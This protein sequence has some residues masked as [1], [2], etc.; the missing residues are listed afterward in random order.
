M[1]AVVTW[2]SLRILDLNGAVLYTATGSVNFHNLLTLGRKLGLSSRSSADYNGVTNPGGFK[3]LD[4]TGTPGS[5]GFGS[6]DTTFAQGAGTGAD[7]SCGI[8][9]ADATGRQIA[10]GTTTE[11]SGT[12]YTWN[13]GNASKHMFKIGPDGQPAA[14][15]NTNI[16]TGD[17]GDTQVCGIDSHGRVYFTG[18][19]MSVN[20]VATSALYRLYRL[21]ASGGLDQELDGFDG[22][23]NG[24]R[25]LDDDRILAFGKFTS[26]AGAPAG[27]VINLHADGRA[28]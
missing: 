11:W 7:P 16:E 5:A 6:I 21:T 9:V 10:I 19:V 20:G 14:T 4:F 12:S 24:C 26:Y 28:Y 3:L 25:V 17:N 23:V 15:W 1:V 27:Y 18:P 13:G 2:Q 8:A 22:N